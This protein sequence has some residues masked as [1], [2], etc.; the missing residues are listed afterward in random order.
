MA[1]I[2]TSRPA[3]FGAI[4]TYR[5]VNGFGGIFS[6]FKAWNDARVT[7]KAL[8][9]LSDRELDDIGLCRGDIE[10]LGR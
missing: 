4:T 1:A 6:A 9:K 3:P 2:E 10:M 8:S 7:R 5:A